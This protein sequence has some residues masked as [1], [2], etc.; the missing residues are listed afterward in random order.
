MLSTFAQLLEKD[1]SVSIHIRNLQ[2]LVTEIFKARNNLSPSIV[3]NIFKRTE[4]AY[5]LRRET[6]F[7]SRKIQTQRQG[8]ESLTYLGPK[9]WSQVPNETKESASLA[10]L[11]NKIKNWRPK[12]CP[13]KLCKT[14]MINLGYLYRLFIN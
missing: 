6:I 3:K 2:V 11:K 14:Y 9:I 10:V 5:S 1:S 8:M 13:C 12:L 7:G 4:P